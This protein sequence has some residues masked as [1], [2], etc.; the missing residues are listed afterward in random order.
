MLED[1]LSSR[2]ATDQLMAEQPRL[3]RPRTELITVLPQQCL[4]WL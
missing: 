4:T 1:R 3:E 2:F